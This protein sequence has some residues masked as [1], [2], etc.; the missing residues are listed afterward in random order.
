MLQ[1]AAGDAGRI[2]HGLCSLQSYVC[3]G[4]GRYF[5]LSLKT[6]C[7]LSAVPSSIKLLQEE[8][9]LYEAAE[10]RHA[11]L[12]QCKLSPSYRGTRGPLPSSPA[13]RDSPAGYGRATGRPAARCSP[14]RCP[15]LPSAA[16]RPARAPQVPQFRPSHPPPPARRSPRSS[17]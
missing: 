15:A 12:S 14:G 9:R 11:A 1:Q 16:P 10:Q 8:M 5:K 4:D 2:S 13:M 7:Y 17:D 3:S 6:R